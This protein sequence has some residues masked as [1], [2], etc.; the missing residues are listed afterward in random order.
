M[1]REEDRSD[2]MNRVN[3]ELMTGRQGVKTRHDEKRATGEASE[4][5]NQGSLP[6]LDSAHWIPLLLLH[7]ACSCPAALDPLSLP[8]LFSPFFSIQT[9]AYAAAAYDYLLAARERSCSVCKRQ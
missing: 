3:Q 1:R 4:S 6:R 2:Q 7:D 9:D 8:H 5:V